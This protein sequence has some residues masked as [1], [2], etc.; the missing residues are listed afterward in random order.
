MLVLSRRPGERV[1]VGDD[2]WITIVKCENGVTKLG[3][4][5]PKAK[6]VL[7]EEMVKAQPVPSACWPLSW[8]LGIAAF[9]GKM[10]F[11]KFREEQYEPRMAD[12]ERDMNE[13]GW[14]ERP[15]PMKAWLTA[16]WS[17][18]FVWVWLTYAQT[19][20]TAATK[21]LVTAIIGWFIRGLRQE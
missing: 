11:R 15:L 6:K 7:R 1:L 3:I 21:V 9:M 16:C 8:I 4:D 17:G 12:L 14:R 19:A 5:A 10:L 18:Q 2:V 13:S 20:M